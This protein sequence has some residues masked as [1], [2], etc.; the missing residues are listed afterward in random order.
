MKKILNLFSVTAFALVIALAIT[1]CAADDD[2]DGG[3]S[4]YLG[5]V[6][7]LSGKVYEEIFDEENM[8]LSYK[9]FKGNMTVTD[10]DMTEVGTIKNGELSFT[11]GTPRL[12][13]FKAIEDD[14]LDYYD[15]ETI[16]P[17]TVKGNKLRLNNLDKGNSAVSGTRTN[18]NSTVE[19]VDYYYVDQD[20]TISGKG[21]TTTY[22]GT[23]DGITYTN[24]ETTKDINFELKAG[25]NA[26]YF[27]TQNSG[28]I[29]GNTWTSTDTTT[30]SLG[31]P[32]LKWVLYED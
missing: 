13:D 16:N 15:N 30:C 9:E 21:K 20:V 1:A 2:D 8:K 26:I 6:L 10:H 27:K 19:W 5:E 3:G 18:Y 29:T 17:S 23:D 24:K 12:L 25:W 22:S 14:F 28:S 31:N 32:N 7:T 11:I 4:P